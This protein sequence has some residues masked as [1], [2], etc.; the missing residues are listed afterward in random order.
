VVGGSAERRIETL[1][2]PGIGWF[3]QWRSDG[4]WR[5]LNNAQ[6]RA[7]RAGC[8]LPVEDEWVRWSGTY[9]PHARG[10]DWDGARAWW[11][12]HGEL[13][14]RVTP[15]V[16]LSDG[17]RPP[18]HVLG[19]VWACEWLSEAQPATALVE[20]EQFNLPFA[21]PLYRRFSAR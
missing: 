4:S 13:P 14:G 9:Q 17:T 1:R 15:R 18:V 2:L 8:H 19:R 6:H 12:L 20:R 10:G 7:E 16:V 3:L 11:L 5:E 21:E